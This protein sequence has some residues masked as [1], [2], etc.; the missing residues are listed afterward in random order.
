MKGKKSTGGQTEKQRARKVSMKNEDRRKRGISWGGGVAALAGLCTVW[1][2]L[3]S[4]CYIPPFLLPLPST[5]FLSCSPTLT[6]LFLFLPGRR[7]GRPHNAGGLGKS[8]TAHKHIQYDWQVTFCPSPH[9][10]SKCMFIMCVCV[11]ITEAAGL[12]SVLFV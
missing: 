4:I 2:C 1:P 8:L 6:I 11:H 3:F 12:E 9:V 5:L 7:Q 10:F